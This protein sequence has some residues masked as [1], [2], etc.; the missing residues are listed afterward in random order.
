LQRT[1][2]ELCQNH[3]TLDSDNTKTHADRDVY[4]GSDVVFS[5]RNWSSPAMVLHYAKAWRNDQ[6]DSFKNWGDKN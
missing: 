1:H 4:F 3:I 6:K 2:L 5:L